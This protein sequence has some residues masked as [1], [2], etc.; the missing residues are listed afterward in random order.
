MSQNLNDFEEFEDD[1]DENSEDFGFIISADGSLKTVLLPDDYD[2][3]PPLEVK[4]I[5][6]IFGIKNLNNILVERTLHWKLKILGKY[7]KAEVII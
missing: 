7:L 1:E 6:K 5:L 3:D 2:G 4:R